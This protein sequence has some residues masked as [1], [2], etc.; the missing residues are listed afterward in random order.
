MLQTPNS[1]MAS[2]A[3]YA[4]AR[5]F[6]GSWGVEEVIRDGKQSS[7]TM[8]RVAMEALLRFSVSGLVLA[9]SA[10]PAWAGPNVVPEPGTF[11]LLALGGVVGLVIAI[12]NRGRKKK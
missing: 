8:G 10:A 7:K 3:A 2:R 9:L 11:E 12:R 4:P 1:R 5:A 6:I